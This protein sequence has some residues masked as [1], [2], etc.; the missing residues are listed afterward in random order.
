MYYPNT[1]K[2]RKMLTGTIK[3]TTFTG[4]PTRTTF[5]NTLRMYFYTKFIKDRHGIRNFKHYHA[6]DDVLVLTDIENAT[7]F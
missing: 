5:G 3:G 1:L 2:K 4:H 6:G 7:K